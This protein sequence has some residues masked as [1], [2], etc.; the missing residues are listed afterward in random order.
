MIGLEKEP[1][2]LTEKMEE[3]TR[4]IEQAEGSETY[5][6]VSSEFIHYA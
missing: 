1:D 5:E 3:L 6:P 4:T 2:H